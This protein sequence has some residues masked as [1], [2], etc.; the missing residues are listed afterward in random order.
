[1]S[2]K[3]RPSPNFSLAD[4]LHSNAIHLLRELRREDRLTGLSPARLSALS[5]A[6]FAGPLTISQLAR[7]EQV[8]TPTMTRLVQAL[9][10][11]G[12][13]SRRQDSQDGRVV[14]VVATERGAEVL[15]EGRAR[16]VARLAGM[17]ASLPDEQIQLLARGSQILAR[18][19]TAL[20]ADRLQE[21]A[22]APEPADDPAKTR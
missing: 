12:L 6:V 2:S 1:M 3:S 17:L 19:L 10:R 21:G 20:K 8:K 5:L 14:R 22:T 4:R 9:E 15:R 11:E 18:T 16:R 7:A 13:V